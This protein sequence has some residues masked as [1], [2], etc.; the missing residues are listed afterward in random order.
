MN[1]VLLTSE[2]PSGLAHRLETVFVLCCFCHRQSQGREL[3][4]DEVVLGTVAAETHEHP[5]HIGEDIARA[6]DG[7]LGMSA[8]VQVDAFRDLVERTPLKSLKVP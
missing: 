1:L 6:V 5:A 2:S 3:E 7:I 4:S 8:R